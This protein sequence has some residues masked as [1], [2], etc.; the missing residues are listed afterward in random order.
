[1]PVVPSIDGK[2]AAGFV[3]D[4]ITSDPETVE[5]V[6]PESAVKRAVT[7]LTESLSIAGARERVGGVVTVGLLDS[8]L[9]LKTTTARVEVQIVP[10]AHERTIRQLPVHWRNLDDQMA[11]EFMPSAVDIRLRGD[12]EALSRVTADGVTI[13]VDVMG[14]GAGK[15]SLPVR[16]ELRGGV[17]SDAT[18]SDVGIAGTDPSLVQVQITRD[19]N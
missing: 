10:A 14:L 12:R 1:V 2:P 17:R 3:V 7:A 15:Y 5:I 18:L 11:A 9:R 4:K 19:K 13:Y 16:A 6:G 8:T